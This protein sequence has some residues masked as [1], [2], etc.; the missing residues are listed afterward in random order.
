MP[1]LA[2]SVALPPKSWDEFEDI[3][4]SAA[5]CRWNHPD[6]TRHGRQGQKQDGVDVYGN[7]R[8]GNLI[9]YQCKNTIAGVSEDTIKIEIGNAE[10][11]QPALS[12]LYLAT[13]AK[14]DRGL[15]KTVRQI[16]AARRKAGKFAVDILFWVDVWQDLALDPR[17][18]TKHFPQLA[19]LTAKEDAK[20]GHDRELFAKFQ[21]VLPFEPSGRLMRDHDFGADFPKSSTAHLYTFVETWGQPELEFLDPELQ[22]GLERF[23][24]AAGTMSDALVRLTVP[25]NANAEWLTVYPDSY[26][27]GRR[28][29]WVVK[30]AAELNAAAST[31]LPEYQ[32]FIRLCKMRLFP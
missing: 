30:D 2:A 20:L 7:D 19:P 4:C 8:E 1:T 26:R 31:Y 9:G 23:F 28:P 3:V 5:Q 24:E 22:Q 10:K 6:F 17:Q 16:S 27:G 32:R 21:A 15:Q 29:D 11:F 18:L 13:T 25:L 12:H 14:A